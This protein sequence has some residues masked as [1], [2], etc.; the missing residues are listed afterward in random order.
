VPAPI[1]GQ[2]YQEVFADEFDSLNRAWWD[3]HIWY[4]GA[5]NPAWTGFQTVEN[6]ILHLRTSRNF[7]GSNGRPYPLNTITTQTSGKT[8]QY[9]YFEA[10]MKW[11]GGFNGPWPGFWLYSYRHATNDAYPSVNPF[12]SNNGIPVDQ[13]W[14][15]ELDVFE[16]QGPEPRT[17]YGTIHSNSCDCYGA[18]DQQNDNNADDTG[19][20][21]TADYH[22]Y[23]MLWTPTQVSWYLDGNLLHSAPAYDSLNQPMFMLLQMWQGGWNPDAD[24]TTP[25]TIET[26]VDWVRVWQK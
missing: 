18:K 11:T 2:G 3:D 7:A 9:G 6:G 8:F 16:G 20:D 17:F 12:C 23:G 25:D 4:D 19:I 1:A 22:T 15:G 5:P 24:S 26:D 14:S 10:R 13:C 21:L